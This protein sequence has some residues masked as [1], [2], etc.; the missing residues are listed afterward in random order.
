M[1]PLGFNISDLKLSDHFFWLHFLQ[2]LK[3]AQVPLV[4]RGTCQA[5]YKDLGPRYTITKRMRCAGFAK[6]GVDACQGDSGGP[7]VC[8]NNGKWYLMGSVSFGRGCARKNRFGVYA[9][10]LELMNWV[11]KNID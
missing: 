3:Q 5:A 4:S 7:L 9:D 11:E 10:L 8:P 6:G 1:E 2:I